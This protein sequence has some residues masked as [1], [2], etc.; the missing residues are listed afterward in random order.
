[1]QTTLLFGL[2]ANPPTTD[3][4][5][6]LVKQILKMKEIKA[7]KGQVLTIKKLLILPVYEH[8]FRNKTNKKGNLAPYSHRLKMA[9]LAFAPLCAEDPRISV[10][11][12]EKNYFHT[13]K[14][15][16][17]FTPNTYDLIQFL[18]A[19]D[20][21]SQFSLLL[22]ADCINSLLKGEWQ[23]SEKLLDEIPIVAVARMGSPSRDYLKISTLKKVSST[24][25]RN[26]WNSH[27]STNVPESVKQ[28]ILANSLYT[29]E[30]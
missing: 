7:L 29:E 3:G 12:Y 2:S 14:E 30:G 1:M 13:C 4:H 19:Q 9:Q 26:D 8:P 18:Q 22:G 11:E 20:S 21:T 23:H 16:K 27:H 17:L 24:Q 15:D 5:V 28:Y 10:V 25:I 6:E